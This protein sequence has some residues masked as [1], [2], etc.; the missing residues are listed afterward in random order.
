MK[1]FQELAS[2]FS[3]ASNAANGGSL[4][5]RKQ[6]DLPEVFFEALNKKSKGFIAGPIK[7]GA[8]Y[9]LLELTD[10]EDHLSFMKI[11]GK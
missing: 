4:G 10:K 9:H 3:V 2:S 5:W 6:N 11:N 8:G 1:I 7:T